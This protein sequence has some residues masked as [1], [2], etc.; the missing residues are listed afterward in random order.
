MWRRRL[1]DAL[2]TESMTTFNVDECVNVVGFFSNIYP[3]F[4]RAHTQYSQA[5][6]RSSWSEHKLN[7]TLLMTAGLQRISR[8]RVFRPGTGRSWLLAAGGN[9]LRSWFPLLRR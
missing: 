6:L 5:T 4:A 7:E 2:R 1:I 3:T 8:L 9:I